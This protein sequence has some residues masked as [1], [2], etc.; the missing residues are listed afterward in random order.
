[1]KME[2]GIFEYLESKGINLGHAVMSLP[3]D[4]DKYFSN[5]GCQCC[6]DGMG[7][8]YPV[9]IVYPACHNAGKDTWEFNLCGDCISYYYNPDQA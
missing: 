5:R 4:E 2:T 1:M 7:E 6:N 9:T 3:D 8:V